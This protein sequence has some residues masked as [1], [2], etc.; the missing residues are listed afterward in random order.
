MLYWCVCD[1]SGLIQSRFNPPAPLGETISQGKTLKIGSGGMCSL[2]E[3]RPENI[4]V[5]SPCRVLLKPGLPGSGN[6]VL[7]WFVTPAWW[8]EVSRG[9]SMRQCC[10]LTNDTVTSGR[11][12]A[13]LCRERNCLWDVAA[14]VRFQTGVRSGACKEMLSYLYLELLN[15]T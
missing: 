1:S 2:A 12:Q 6:D 11:R 8:T 3:I 13:G 10:L 9:L 14:R 7:R 5:T 4:K 15:W